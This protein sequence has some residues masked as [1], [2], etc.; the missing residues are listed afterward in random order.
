MATAKHTRAR[1]ARSV[2]HRVKHY[3]PPPDSA[4]G[5]LS[6][7]R[8]RLKFVMAAA[9]TICAALQFQNA[10]LDEEIALMVG[11]CVGDEIDSQIEAID[12]VIARLPGARR[13]GAPR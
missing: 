2:P 8:R 10:E 11:R 5:M 1:K 7:V 13:K 4:A 6:A 12:R 3:P 9:F